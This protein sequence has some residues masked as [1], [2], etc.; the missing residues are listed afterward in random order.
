M[1]PPGMMGPPLGF[2]GGMGMG[3]GMG[4]YEDFPTPSPSDVL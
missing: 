1:R 3:M 2:P 4:M